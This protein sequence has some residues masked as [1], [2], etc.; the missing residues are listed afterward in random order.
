MLAAG[1]LP[2]CL[3][4]GSLEPHPDPKIPSVLLLQYNVTVVGTDSS[5]DETAGSN[6]KQ[7]TTPAAPPPPPPPRSAASEQRCF[8]PAQHCMPA[9]A[10][11]TSGSQPPCLATLRCGVRY[12][13]RLTPFAAVAV[14]ASRHKGF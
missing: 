14:A 9:L 5:G 11:C 4:V 7:F 1:C 6:M 2:A 13:P 8:V 12:R 3:C 10:P